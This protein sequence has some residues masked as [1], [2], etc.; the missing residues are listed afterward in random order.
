MRRN[1]I[2]KPP[3][4]P[5]AGGLREDI[6]TFFIMAVP[7]GYICRFY[8]SQHNYCTV[9]FA[10]PLAQPCVRSLPVLFF[11][12]DGRK[13]LTILFYLFLITTRFVPASRFH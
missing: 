9:Y 2:K 3:D 4:D 8:K 12:V 7:S 13:W 1:E 11:D 5:G 6:K 10:L